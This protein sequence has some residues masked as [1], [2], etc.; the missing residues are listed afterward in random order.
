M[1]LR[2]IAAGTKQTLTLPLHREL[3]SGTLVAIF[4]Q[5]SRYI[6]ESE[7]HPHFYAE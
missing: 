7:L 6:T 5:A 1:K 4:R 2:R 3:D